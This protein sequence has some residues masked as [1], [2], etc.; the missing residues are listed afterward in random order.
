[1][2]RNS[3]DSWA[4]SEKNLSVGQN[5]DGN[6]IF[7]SE[8]DPEDNAEELECLR[9][10]NTHP[11]DLE[12]LDNLKNFVSSLD[13]MES[14]ENLQIPKSLP[15]P[16]LSEE[17]AIKKIIRFF[18][19][20]QIKNKFNTNPY[21]TYLSLLTTDTS[22][23]QNISRLIFGRHQAEIHKHG[24]GH[25]EN[26]FIMESNFYHRIDKIEIKL[27]KQILEYLGEDFDSSFNYFPVSLFDSFTINEILIQF[28]E[29]IDNL[30]RSKKTEIL[31]AIEQAKQ[32]VIILK[33][34]SLNIGFI[35]FPKSITM[36]AFDS[37]DNDPYHSFK[38]RYYEKLEK[39]LP[40]TGL[41]ISPWEISLIINQFDIQNQ[42]FDTVTLPNDLPK[43]KDEFLQ[44][45]IYKT[46]KQLAKSNYVTSNL[47][48]ALCQL[49]QN[50][51]DFNEAAITRISFVLDI[52]C[53]F[54]FNHYSRYAFYVYVIMHELALALLE[55]N[56]ETKD[57]I[58]EEYQQQTSK[59]ILDSLELT[60]ANISF[61]AL[62]TMSGSHAY[63]LA[64]KLARE[65]LEKE[66][67]LT[68]FQEPRYYE[69]E[70]I[71]NISAKN[72][73]I[74]EIS[75]GPITNEDG[76]NTPIDI[77]DFIEHLPKDRVMVILIDTT[78][79]LYKN[80]KLNENSK[81]LISSGVVSIIIY[82]SRQKFGL[83]H[84]DYIQAGQ[85]CIVT[86][87][88]LFAR[89]NQTVDDVKIDFQTHIDL[90]LGAFITSKC[91]LTLETIKERHFHNGKILRDAL[92]IDQKNA[93]VIQGYENENLD[94]LYFIIC[95]DQLRDK[96]QFVLNDR[97]SFGHFNSTYSSVLSHLRISVGACD[98][99]DILIEACE[100]H[101]EGIEDEELLD[102][103]LL[104]SNID[105]LEFTEQII[106]LAIANRVLVKYPNLSDF[107]YVNTLKLYEALNAITYA[108][109][110]E[111]IGRKT[112]RH[113]EK[114]FYELQQIQAKRI[115]DF[116][117]NSQKFFS[118]QVFEA[119]EISNY[120]NILQQILANTSSE[121]NS[122]IIKFKQ[123]YPLINEVIAREQNDEIK[124]LLENIIIYIKDSC[125][126]IS[127]TQLSEAHDSSEDILENSSHQNRF[128]AVIDNIDEIDST[129][130]NSS[131]T[132]SK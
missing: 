36:D 119:T 47:A 63:T 19:K 49:L 88:Q 111:F 105:E 13:I 125:Q 67:E 68:T 53:T 43:S 12:I 92:E 58:F 122:I 62:P 106:A 54:H 74:F 127:D 129:L 30:N 8:I 16:V 64:R 128:F 107:S 29:N 91:A 17:I 124:E 5:E 31:F 2:F 22:E 26:P 46:L 130:E 75:L 87:Q 83:L 14:L 100:V 72:V 115:L 65:L 70:A 9:F 84:T 113:I 102:I 126:S 51:I 25:I 94:E 78:T 4:S 99:L 116:F 20:Y 7:G 104:F 95:P 40:T 27:F 85:V 59:I 44:S 89:L 112:H 98:C 80:L 108:L 131:Q 56:T 15:Q 123:L 120:L 45:K 121:F 77:N 110:I 21:N 11:F 55:A 69:F 34:D 1:M 28:N 79:A 82:E 41:K 42:R 38:Q 109:N 61:I 48:L 81:N 60:D 33:S 103:L 32:N 6:E 132:L 10:S 57:L 3:F 90:T 93:V 39:Y 24:E 73:D 18:K 118:K 52:A 117:N 37:E 76:L 23:K 66:K 114:S 86:N 96:I 71:Q 101:L 35:K 50:E 97:S